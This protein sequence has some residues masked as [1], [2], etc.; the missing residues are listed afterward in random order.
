MVCDVISAQVNGP[1]NRAQGQMSGVLHHHDDL[2]SIPDQIPSLAMDVYMRPAN[3][4]KPTA[5]GLE[6]PQC[7]AP[8][9]P[10]PPTHRD[11]SQIRAKRGLPK[12][13]ARDT[14]DRQ[15]LCLSSS[16]NLI[17]T[18]APLLGGLRRVCMP[19]SSTYISPHAARASRW[20]SPMCYP[21]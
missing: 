16:T 21:Y 12:C 2:N 14:L 7:S 18:A 15:S 19:P 17:S 9:R 13:E 3:P 8:P 20:F 11:D 10:P 5:L 4:P 1:L 6:K